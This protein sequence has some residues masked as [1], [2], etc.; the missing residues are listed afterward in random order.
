MSSIEKTINNFLFMGFEIR[1][2]SDELVAQLEERWPS[3]PEVVGSNPTK[4]AYDYQFN[5]HSLV[6]EYKVKHFKKNPPNDIQAI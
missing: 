5:I 3:K 1:I 6:V 2:R 4:L